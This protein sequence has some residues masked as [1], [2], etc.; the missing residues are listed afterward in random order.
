MKKNLMAVTLASAMIGS[1]GMGLALADDDTASPARSADSD[2]SVGE[3]IDDT[4][5]LARVKSGLLA[6]SEVEGLDVNVDVRNGVVTLSGTADSM[7]ERQSAERIARSADGVKAV[8]N[9]IVLK[10]EAAEHHS[11]PAPAG[12]APAPAGGNP[13]D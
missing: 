3:A 4:T 8:D 6:S 11:V 12:T 7:A 13:V 5:L 2:R 9:K 10:P 1:L